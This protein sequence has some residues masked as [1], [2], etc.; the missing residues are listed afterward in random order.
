MA[1]KKKGMRVELNPYM[2][3]VLAQLRARVQTRAGREGKD[4][5]DGGVAQTVITASADELRAGLERY[6]Y[7]E[8]RDRSRRKNSLSV[9]QQTLLLRW[10]LEAYYDRGYNKVLHQTGIAAAIDELVER[11]VIAQP[12][13]VE[14]RGTGL[15]KGQIGSQEKAQE[16]K[17]QASLKVGAATR[18]KAIET[19]E[20]DLDGGAA[21]PGLERMASHSR[22]RTRETDRT[23][24]EKKV[25]RPKKRDE[26][27]FLQ[28]HRPPVTGNCDGCERPLA[29][30]ID[31]PGLRRPIDFE[32]VNGGE[33]AGRLR[34]RCTTDKGC[35][36]AVRA[37][38]DAMNRSLHAAGQPP[39]T[40]EV[41]EELANLH[42]AACYRLPRDDPDYD[43]LM[44]EVEASQ[45]DA[46]SATW[47]ER[48]RQ[49]TVASTTRSDA[50]L[51][52]A[53]VAAIAA[54]RE[55]KATRPS[56]V[57]AA[58]T[59]AR[60]AYSAKKR[61]EAAAE[62]AKDEAKKAAKREK[63]HANK[64]KPRAPPKFRHVV[65][66][67]APALS[68]PRKRFAVDRHDPASESMLTPQE[69]EGRRR[70]AKRAAQH[71]APPAAKPAKPAK[72][73]RR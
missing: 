17:L 14:Y 69:I 54:R 59:A 16:R 57:A 25:E 41:A 19:R 42:L 5:R 35:N 49:A 30:S 4:Y 28:K 33:N 71:A 46:A 52:Q 48:H 26:A 43:D 1:P 21:A 34:S 58:R 9:R 66:P 73:A 61:R 40:A 29:S 32:H 56:S 8:G 2:R 50:D 13:A 45:A 23:A 72:R 12:W 20:N 15:Y 37:N 44:R 55:Y 38:I 24:R 65:L 3:R 68:G 18:A 60:A 62:K 36:T 51:G 70:M 6:L 7:P 63:Y 67:P 11:H 31:A 27:A 39:L 53:R 47:T 22:H 10:T 64:G